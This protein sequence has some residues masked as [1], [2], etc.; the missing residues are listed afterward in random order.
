VPDGP[1]E[2]LLSG[3]GMEDSHAVANSLQ[4]GPDGWMP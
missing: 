4:W 1:P 2:V 3:F